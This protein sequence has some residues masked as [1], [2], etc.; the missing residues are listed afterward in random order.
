MSEAGNNQR[1][2]GAPGARF[3]EA[4]RVQNLTTADI[5]RRLKLSV[6]Q[7]EALESGQYDR[8]PGPIFVRGF[9]RNYARLLKLDP[10]ELLQA[11]ADSM[12][13]PAPRS[14]TPPS[15]DI[16]F[17]TSSA[18]RWP[19]YVMGA[20]AVVGLL[21]I[22]AFFWDEVETAETEPPTVTATPAPAP[23]QPSPKRTAEPQANQPPVAAQPAPRVAQ[24]APPAV[25]ASA[26]PQSERMTDPDEREVRLVFDEESW[27]EI[28]DRNDTVIFYQLNASGTVRRVRGLPPLSIVVGNAHGVRMTYGGQPIDLARH[29]R[30]DV[31]RLT[32]E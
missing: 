32:L 7:V 30:I 2:V 28:R 12:P 15:P 31:A 3:S 24:E 5:A 29:T 20:A 16:P 14:E 6:W 4:R 27:V 1:S 11:A 8:L 26:P 10:E 13:Q 19:K 21:A 23:A 25:V 22:Y 17:P 9:I 18:R